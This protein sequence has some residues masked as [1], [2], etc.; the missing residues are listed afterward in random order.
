MNQ[1]REAHPLGLA[2]PLPRGGMTS[3]DPASGRCGGYA[4]GRRRVQRRVPRRV[5]RRGLTASATV[6]PGSDR[7][8]CGAC[9]RSSTRRR[10]VPHL[11][12][13]VAGGQR[14]GRVRSSAIEAG[15]RTRRLG[16][17]AFG[18]HL[19]QQPTSPADPSR[20]T[21]GQRCRS[22][23]TGP[24][25]SLVASTPGGGAS[26]RTPLRPSTA[27][28]RA[29]RGCYV[30]SSPGSGSYLVMDTTCAQAASARVAWR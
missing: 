7:Q 11:P 24:R 12:P 30:L 27:P 19:I 9:Q 2:A 26:P 5:Q 3:S 22:C 16:G 10:R 4:G 23:A 25:A 17:A 15:G 20:L 18:G 29:L 14:G 6:A 13:T 21:L 8:G 1:S 28:G